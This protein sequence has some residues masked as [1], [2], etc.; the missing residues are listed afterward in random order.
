MMK[1]QGTDQNERGIN[2]SLW[3]ALKLILHQNSVRAEKGNVSNGQRK[4]RD[5]KICKHS[6]G[7][8]FASGNVFGRM[9]DKIRWGDRRKKSQ[10]LK[11]LKFFTF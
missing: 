8:G 6:D 4:C 1:N 9:R 3:E 11:T 7:V 2:M 5:C 10:V